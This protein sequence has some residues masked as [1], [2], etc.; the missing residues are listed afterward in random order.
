V[1]SCDINVLIYAFD[2]DTQ[3]HQEYRDWLLDVLDGPE[4]F[5]V[6]SQVLAGFVRI[7]THPRLPRN[8]S[9]VERAIAFAEQVRS[10]P[11]AVALEPGARHWPIFVELCTKAN[12]KGNLII[13]AYLAALAMEHRCEWNTTD[14]DFARFPGL[15]WRHPLDH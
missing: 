3:R 9:S 10:A 15:R 4:E 2:V 13:D 12:A 6:A 7:V 11:A 1:R 5:G 14:R 8:P